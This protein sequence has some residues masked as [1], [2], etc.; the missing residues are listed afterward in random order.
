MTGFGPGASGPGKE[1]HA[2]LKASNA[3]HNVSQAGHHKEVTEEPSVEERT[4]GVVCPTSAGRSRSTIKAQRE[5][6]RSITAEGMPS[7]LA[8]VVHS[9]ERLPGAVKVGVV[10]MV[11]AA[12]TKG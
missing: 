4:E 12:S 3:G 9:R 1:E 2:G 8:I 10:A 5:H 7:D 11:K 6:N